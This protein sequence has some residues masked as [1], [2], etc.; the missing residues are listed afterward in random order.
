M[1]DVNQN[2][3]DLRIF[4]FDLY[5]YYFFYFFLGRGM[6]LVFKDLSHIILFRTQESPLLF[7][8]FFLIF[9]L[10]VLTRP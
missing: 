9:T 5:F 10:F 4:L 2:S 7:F 1:D 6:S 8:F 3:I